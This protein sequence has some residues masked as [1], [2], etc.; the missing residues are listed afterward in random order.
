MMKYDAIIFGNGLNC[1]IASELKKK[2]DKK[3]QYLFDLK[4]FLE[5]LL[6]YENKQYEDDI[7]KL[8]EEILLIS[9][10]CRFM[11]L[12]ERL[13]KYYTEELPIELICNIETR[14]MPLIQ[15]FLQSI[16][17]D[18]KELY[19]G[20]CVETI[21]REIEELQKKVPY[22]SNTSAKT[23]RNVKVHLERLNDLLT[24]IYI[25]YNIH[26]IVLNW[27][28]LNN[29][30]LEELRKKYYRNFFETHLDTS[31]YIMTTNYGEE[32]KQH[33]SNAEYLH[34]SF[35]SCEEILDRDGRIKDKLKIKRTDGE[36]SFMFGATPVKKHYV[37]EKGIYDDRLFLDAKSQGV[38]YYGDLLIYG[39]S[40]AKVHKGILNPNTTRK[41][42]YENID[43]HIMKA[44]NDLFVNQRICSV[45]IV[46]YSEDDN[47]RYQG[48]LKSFNAADDVI[49]GQLY[50]SG[51]IR[52]ISNEEF[53][54][55]NRVRFWEKLI[56]KITL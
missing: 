26:A 1:A 52:I 32:I 22:Y 13:L 2:C 10:N 29:Q 38:R 12:Y 56:K 42:F 55:E 46:A 44:I 39:M 21:G 28:I 16:T 3:Y 5:H 54:K 41:M 19:W 37:I 9:S 31:A 49:I 18:R 11:N 34:G 48:F 36:Y 4:T 50:A 17:N 51:K 27:Y 45:T 35:I 43:T 30:E 20:I 8:A 7:V 47:K 53:E 14:L 15:G 24:D 25:L 40:F 6:K 23:K 33:Y